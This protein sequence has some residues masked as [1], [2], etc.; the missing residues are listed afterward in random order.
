MQKICFFDRVK[1]FI[2]SRER[3][4]WPVQYLTTNLNTELLCFDV[5]HEEGEA[6]LPH[7]VFGGKH[8]LRREK[9][10]HYKRLHTVCLQDFYPTAMSI[11]NE[12]FQSDGYKSA[13]L[14]SVNIHQNKYQHS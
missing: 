11:L 14:R 13:L 1:Y 2:D 8:D 3:N 6:L 12:T 10:I 9:T 5:M 7:R 4:V